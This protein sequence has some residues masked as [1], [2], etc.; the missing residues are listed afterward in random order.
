MTQFSAKKSTLVKPNHAKIDNKQLRRGVLQEFAATGLQHD[1][2]RL[3]ECF[4][5][6]TPVFLVGGFVRDSVRHLLG[7]SSVAPKDIDIVIDTTELARCMRYQSGKVTRTPLG[8]FRWWPSPG[9]YRHQSWIDVWQLQD[10]IWIKQMNLKPTIDNTLAGFDLNI[11]R[12]AFG[13]HDQSLVDRGCLSGIDARVIDLDA[14]IRLEN[15]L[16]FEIARAVIAH[17]KTSYVLSDRVLS[18]LRQNST[19]VLS[20]QVFDRLRKD[21]YSKAKLRKLRKVVINS[22]RRK[23]TGRRGRTAA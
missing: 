5:A 10:T 14:E 2:S 18:L 9:G 1:L 20:S 3:Q 8:G 6:E 17:L 23:T 13:L 15:L 7:E 22:S 19:E 4:S 21:G 12:I 16:S 11:N